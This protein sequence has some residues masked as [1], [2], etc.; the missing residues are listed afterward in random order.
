MEYM[1]T[2]PFDIDEGEL[3][4]LEANKCYV[5]GFELGQIYTLFQ[6]EDWDSL[7]GRV[8]HLE[9]RERVK[10]LFGVNN[11]PMRFDYYEYAP[12]W[13]VLIIEQ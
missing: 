12:E 3:Y 9:N 6:S 10:K 11:I 8:V 5:L 13:A 2:F 4:G 1:I 7:Q